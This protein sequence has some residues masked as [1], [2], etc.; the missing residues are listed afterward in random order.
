MSLDHVKYVG[1][2]HNTIS[3][4]ANDVITSNEGFEPVSDLLKQSG[5]H[6]RAAAAT[7]DEGLISAL[8]LHD[9]VRSLGKVVNHMRVH[10]P[11]NPRTASAG[12]DLQSA[13]EAA[14]QH[15]KDCM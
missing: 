9:A 12:I 11:N 8:H 5:F 4:A 14:V 1:A 15:E 3:K 6:I 10:A 13:L 7:H 2:F